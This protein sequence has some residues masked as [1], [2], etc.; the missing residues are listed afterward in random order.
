MMLPLDS[1]TIRARLGPALLAIVPAIAL[2]AATIS[3]SKLS[4]PDAIITV[5]IVVI[6]FLF[7]DVARRLGKRSEKRIF[8]SSGGR[9]PLR[10]LRHD[11]PTFSKVERTRYRG[12]LTTLI[13]TEAPSDRKETAN[14]AAADAYYSMAGNW[15]REH[16]RDKSR[17]RILFEEN[18]T[19]GFRR[20]LYGIKWPALGLNLVVVALCVAY[21]WANSYAPA[22]VPHVAMVLVFAIIHAVLFVF[23]VNRQ[24]VVN[25]SDDY[26][27][28]LFLC[29][30]TLGEATAGVPAADEAGAD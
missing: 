20:N 19:Y 5:G 23:V 14:A 26:G 16:T 9:P 13:G 18:V 30:E 29:L 10:Q 1:Y 8:A 4:L 6:F 7:A 12:L 22:L 21:F 25:A 11:D 15:L 17:F 27:R 28:Q 24:S 2:A 3:W